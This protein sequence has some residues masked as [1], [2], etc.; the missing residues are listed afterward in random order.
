MNILQ[1][2]L[3]DFVAEPAPGYTCGILVLQSL[4]HKKKF[5]V[6]YANKNVSHVD[7]TTQHF[8]VARI[9]DEK[10]FNEF[11][12]AETMLLNILADTRNNWPHV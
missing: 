6:A 2:C 5:C 9:A 11:K 4:Q 8:Y 12:I 3:S 10:L 1:H 7:A